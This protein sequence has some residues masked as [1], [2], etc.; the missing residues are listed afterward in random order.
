MDYLIIDCIN[1]YIQNP[2]YISILRKC[3]KVEK[4]EQNEN[5][6]KLKYFKLK[7]E[8]RI[9]LKTFSIFY[10]HYLEDSKFIYYCQQCKYPILDYRK[11]S[12][13]FNSRFTCL[14]FCNSCYR[15]IIWTYYKKNKRYP[16]FDN[17]EL[18]ILNLEEQKQIN[19]I[20]FPK[21]YI[22]YHHDIYTFLN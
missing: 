18:S 2:F 4:E 21:F 19:K 6:L 13:V 5:I 3:L 14:C 10:V 22:A 17:V 9:K 15:N 8:K 11:F 20:C 7:K 1:Q 16:R 12:F